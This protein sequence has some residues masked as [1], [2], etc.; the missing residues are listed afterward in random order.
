MRKVFFIMFVS[1]VLLVG[2]KIG[3]SSTTSTNTD[4][5]DIAKEKFEEEI[6]VPG[7]EYENIELKPKE[8]LPNKIASKISKIIEK[9]CDKIA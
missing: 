2:V 1:L 6:I 5:F 4:L 8:Y 3:S 9:I 7:N